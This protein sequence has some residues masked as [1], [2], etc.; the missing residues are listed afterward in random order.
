MTRTPL[1]R[2]PGLRLP[3]LQLEIFT[4]GKPEGV[5]IEGN[6]DS[7]RKKTNS[8]QTHQRR[9]TGQKPFSC[10]KCDKKF[11]QKGNVKSHE[12]THLQKKSFLCRLDGCGK[13]FSQLGNMKVRAI[14]VV[15][16]IQAETDSNYRHT[17]TTFIKKL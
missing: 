2:S 8:Y 7:S 1:T 5:C 12:E 9:H 6:E 17:R 10:S 14:C 15:M 3:R 13:R 4:I 16:L 11:A